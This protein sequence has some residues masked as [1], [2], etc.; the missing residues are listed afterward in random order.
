M[1]VYSGSVCH[2]RTAISLF[3]LQLS[4]RS[5]VDVHRH[6]SGFSSNKSSRVRTESTATGQS[7]SVPL[8]RSIKWQQQQLVH[9]FIYWIVFDWWDHNNSIRFSSVGSSSWGGTT[10]INR[11]LCSSTAPLGWNTNIQPKVSTLY[12][13]D[14]MAQHRPIQ[15]STNPSSRSV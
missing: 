3:R 13:S 5:G 7:F 14:R 10:T 15:I 9:I 11:R 6:S 8:R 12:C 2:D 1:F 4:S